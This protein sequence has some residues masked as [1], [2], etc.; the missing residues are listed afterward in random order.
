MRS[1]Q[2]EHERVDQQLPVTAEEIQRVL[3]AAAATA[4]M[5]TDDSTVD[6]VTIQRRATDARSATRLG[7]L[8]GDAAQM[9]DW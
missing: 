6:D 7:R 2:L 4:N 1:V 5:L 3:E 9:N 8:G